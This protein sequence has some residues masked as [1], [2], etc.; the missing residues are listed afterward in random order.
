MPI[1][2]AMLLGRFE[3]ILNLILYLLLLKFK[4]VA[5]DPIDLVNPLIP[6]MEI[7]S[8]LF[9]DMSVGIYF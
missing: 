9:S 8:F 6:F 5:V 1:N 4:I 7:M 2:P 3:T